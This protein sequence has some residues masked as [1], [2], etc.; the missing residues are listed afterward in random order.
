MKELRRTGRRRRVPVTLIAVMTLLAA[1]L[2]SSA[3]AHEGEHAPLTLKQDFI[4]LTA[5]QL[6]DMGISNEPG[7]CGE[8]AGEV[9]WHFVTRGNGAHFDTA[10]FVFGGDSYDL[11]ARSG[12]QYAGDDL[13]GIYFATA[14]DATLDRAQATGVSKHGQFVLSHVCVPETF[15]INAVLSGTKFVRSQGEAGDASGWNI[16]IFELPLEDPPVADYS[17]TTDPNGEWSQEVGPY[18][19][20]DPDA[21]VQLAV[22]EE[23]RSGFEQASPSSGDPDTIDVD[24]YG[25][26]HLVTL[27]TDTELVPGLDFTNVEELGAIAITKTAKHAD[28]SGETSADLEATFTVKDSGGNTVGTITTDTAGNG[29]LDGLAFDTYSIEE[30][31]V[32]SGY[33]APDID[34]VTV[35]AIA[36]CGDADQVEVDVENTPLTNI[37]WTVDSQ[38]DGGTLTT[39]TCY[40]SDGNIIDGYPMTVGDGSDSFLSLPPTDPDTTIRCDFVVDP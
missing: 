32:P 19:F 33:A 36:D 17:T 38:H 13:K 8:E 5:A 21:E 10:D 3:I 18:V 24:G 22:C 15:E 12:S 23:Q 40:D 30:T 20:T 11:D 16:S 7:T 9:G 29:C 37:S 28:D 14:P 4:G 1:L 6:A 26:C 34:P 39:V 2:G 27:T 31:G 25:T 35:D